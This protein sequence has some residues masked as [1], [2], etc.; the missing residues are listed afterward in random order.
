MIT[1]HYITM[2]RLQ[3][4]SLHSTAAAGQETQVRNFF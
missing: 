1:T 4:T 3:I 2:L